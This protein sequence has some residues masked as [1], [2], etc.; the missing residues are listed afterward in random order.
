MAARDFPDITPSSRSYRPGRQPET[1]FKAQNGA[2]TVIAFGTRFVDAELDMEFKN[3][4]DQ[5]ANDILVHYQ[6]VRND[7][8]AVFGNDNSLGG[9]S[10]NLRAS[11]QTGMELLRYRYKEP[12][13]IES[14]YPGVSTVRCSF[15][16]L[17]YGV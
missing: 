16:G 7:D 10:R 3:I 11:M 8:F 15:I 6:T 13:R 17:L 1:V 4:S 2:S 12:P 5:A 9:M 14:V